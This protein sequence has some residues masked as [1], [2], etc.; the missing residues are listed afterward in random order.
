MPADAPFSKY[1]AVLLV[2]FGGP[3]GMDDVMPFL[4]NVLRG[5]NV[6]RE[7]ML[8]VAKH[9]ERFGGVSPIN[10]QNRNL[11]AALSAELETNGPHLPVYF[12]NRNWHP[13]LTDTLAQMRADGIKSA[14]AFVTSAYSSYS[15]CRQYLENIASARDLVGPGAP[16]VEKLRPFF[17]HPG[18]I[19]ANVENIKAK[20][21][22]TSEESRA[23]VVLIFTAH[24][25]PE[26][27][28]HN[29]DYETQLS[30]AGRLIAEESGIKD[31]HLVFQSR[32]GSP[33]QPWLGPDVCEF[34]QD[35]KTR[36]VNDVVVAPI[37]FIS[38]HMEV[39]YDLDVQA[40]ELSDR[41][42]LRM[43]RAAT[44]GTHPAFVKMIRELIM[45]K[46]DPAQEKR[47][48]GQFPP[49]PTCGVG[50]CLAS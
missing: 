47:F 32:S 48:L 10:Q 7:R 20:L 35:L 28:A 38:D 40:R 43:R 30:E 1:D 37:G 3:E 36:G 2:S 25:I 22:E 41:I 24:S 19:Q 26:A 46:L 33:T 13:L 11:L 39:I 23:T 21:L 29:C 15:S 17:N 5:R 45:E 9:Y 16:E 49:G 50:C 6:P 42:G 44:A 12:G 31:W 8:G 18:F 14:L 4:E 27:M 34:L